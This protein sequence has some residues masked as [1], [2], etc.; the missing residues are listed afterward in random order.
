MKRSIYVLSA[1]G[2]LMLLSTAL[3]VRSRERNVKA[4]PATVATSREGLIAAP[5][6][7][8][9][10]SEEIRVSSELNGRLHSVPVEEGDHVRKGQVLAQLENEDYV[11]RVAEAEAALAQ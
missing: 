3:F 10:I 9:A 4:A 6:R 1:A 5:G 2:I 8:E 11:A 7:V